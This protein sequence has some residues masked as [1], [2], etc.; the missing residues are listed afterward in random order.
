M[1]VDELRARAKAEVD[2]LGPVPANPREHALW[3]E[4]RRGAVVFLAALA[5]YNRELL[6]E[7]GDG[8]MGEHHRTGSVAGRGARLWL[9]PQTQRSGP[10]PLRVRGSGRSARRLVGALCACIREQ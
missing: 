10:V 9:T 4:E 7:R 3:V 2:E 1:D 6:R 8:R 5:D